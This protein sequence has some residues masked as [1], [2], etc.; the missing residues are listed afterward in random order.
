MKHRRILILGG[1]GFVGT[2]FS[3]RLARAGIEATVLTRHD[4]RRDD[5]WVLPNVRVVETDVYDR[6]KLTHE[7]RG[8]DA[9]VNLVGILNEKG[10]KG[11]GFRR[12]HVTLVETLLAACREAGVKRLLHMSALG[13]VRGESHYLRTKRE[14][15]KLVLAARDELDV[16]VFKPSV[17][18][19]PG[20]GFYRRFGSLARLLPVLPL[21]CPDARFAPVFVGNVA[22]AFLCALNDRNTFGRSYELCG[23]RAYSLREVVAYA[24]DLKDTRCLIWGL[25]DFLARLQ[26]LVC[27]FVPGK[28]FSTDNYKS[29]KTDSVCSEEGLRELGIH[30]VSVEAAVPGYLGNTSRDHR[31]SAY[32]SRRPAE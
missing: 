5:L 28:P 18:F 8:H 32:R 12:A 26:A 23:P 19:G 22:E 29:L 2:Q 25:P 20:D 30:A 1:T 27:D 14:A 7:L 17:I 31:L 6:D 3:A 15:E 10:R 13:T 4:R 9:A 24:R 11:K 21:A 16:T